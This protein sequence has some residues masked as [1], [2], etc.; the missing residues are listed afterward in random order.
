[1]IPVAPVGLCAVVPTGTL[2]AS[3]EPDIS[4][5][6]TGELVLIPIASAE[7]SKKNWCVL[8]SD[9]ILKSNAA[10]AS[11]NVTALVKLA[12]PVMFAFKSAYESIVTLPAVVPSSPDVIAAAISSADSCQMIETYA[13]APLFKN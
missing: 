2:K 4:S 1:M 7:P 5:S 6:Y 12:P 11:L 10:P 8:L 3:V 13:S 9:S